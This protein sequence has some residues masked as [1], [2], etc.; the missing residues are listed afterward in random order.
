MT[1]QLLERR[2]RLIRMRDPDQLDLVELMLTNHPARVLAIRPGFGTKARRMRSELER[3]VAHR[4][5]L[6]AHLVGERDLRGGDQV[7]LLRAMVAILGAALGDGKHVVAELRQLSGTEQRRGVDDVRRIALGVAV[8][9]R[10]RVEHELRER[11]MQPRHPR[12]HHGEAR[13]RK[14]R[15]GREVDHT[16]RFTEVRVVLRREVER[17]RCAPATHLDV[18]GFGATDRHARMPEVRHL[19]HHFAEPLLDDVQL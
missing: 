4:N 14:L 15:P 5:D 8:V 11:A 6:V 18:V 3:Q 1:H 7:E 19:E 12:A 13:A 10:V 16:Q 2:V 17:P 9:A